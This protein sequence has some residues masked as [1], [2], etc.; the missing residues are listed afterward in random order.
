MGEHLA[1]RHAGP[2]RMNAIFPAMDPL[3]DLL[4]VVRLDGAFFYPVEAAEPWSV[5][6]PPARELTPRIMPSAEHLISY[7]I[8]TEGRCYGGVRGE[9]QVEMGAGDVLVSP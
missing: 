3:S 9:D 4:R 2:G 5:A 1:D 6:S 8:L 7:H